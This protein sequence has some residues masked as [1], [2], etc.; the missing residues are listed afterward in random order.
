MMNEHGILPS[1]DSQ[2]FELLEMFN[3]VVIQDHDFADLLPS[4]E[5]E[6]SFDR[7]GNAYI[8]GQLSINVKRRYESLSPK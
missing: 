4:H 7:S 1:S 5:F 8:D 3:Q 2:T 6:L